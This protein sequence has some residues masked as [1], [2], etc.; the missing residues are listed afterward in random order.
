MQG[1]EG[2]SPAGSLKSPEGMRKYDGGSV[3]HHG[4]WPLQ[5]FLD[6]ETR[7]KR[8]TEV[9]SGVDGGRVPRAEDFMQGQEGNELVGRG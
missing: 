8:G 1:N 6:G 4:W 7:Q 3:L 9:K 2:G 5:R